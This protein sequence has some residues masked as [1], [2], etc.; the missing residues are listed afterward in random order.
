MRNGNALNLRHGAELAVLQPSQR[1][2]A[3][4]QLRKVGR[5]RLAAARCRS[6]RD[7]ARFQL[8][9]LS[10]LTARCRQ[11]GDGR[12]AR[13]TSTTSSTTTAPAAAACRTPTCARVASALADAA[14][15]ASRR[16]RGG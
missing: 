2:T 3:E 6:L 10:L 14:R 16:G 7:D 11:L 12:L 15:A 1:V 4:R 9:D 5:H 8:L 13:V